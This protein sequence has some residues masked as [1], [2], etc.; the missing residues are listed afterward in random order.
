MMLIA[1]GDT[2]I[3]NRTDAIDPQ[4]LE[5]I[6]EKM[7]EAILF[8][9]DATEYSTLF[10]LEKLA[11]VY[12]VRGN[13][14]KVDTPKMQSLE[15]G[16]KKVLLLHGNQFGR[17]NYDDLITYARGHEILV[18]GHTH[19]QEHFTK[20]GVLVVNPGS[21]TGAP[22]A[23]STGNKTFTTI[24]INDEVE[25]VEYVVKKDGIQ[26]KGSKGKK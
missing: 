10:L 19:K 8:T 16:G 18:C 3:P 26:S 6:D 14:D 12:A 15:F 20:D 5:F 9:G 11:P 1:L 2:H 25:V 22:G 4:I 24:I 7:P 23:V 21:A 17:G 13:M